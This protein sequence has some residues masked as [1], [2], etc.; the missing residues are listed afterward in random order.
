MLKNVLNVYM[1]AQKKIHDHLPKNFVNLINKNIKTILQY[2][3][4]KKQK[5][6]IQF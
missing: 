3:N 1:L 5:I 2:F 6:S 4:L